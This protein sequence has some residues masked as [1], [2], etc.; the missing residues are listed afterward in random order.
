MRPN[1]PQNINVSPFIAKALKDKAMVK[2]YFNGE[3]TIQ[4]LKEN[5]IELQ[6]LLPN[7]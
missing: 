7:K 2:K 4:Q 3:I 6:K 5:G 1:E